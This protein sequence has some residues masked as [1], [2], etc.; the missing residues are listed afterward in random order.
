MEIPTSE[1]PTL[2]EL[3]TILP[4]CRNWTREKRVMIGLLCLLCI[5]IF[6]ISSNSRL[7]LHCAKRLMDREAF[8]RYLWGRVGF[9]SLLESIKVLTYEGKKSY[10]LHS[11]VHVLLI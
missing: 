2:K 11:Y 9:N 10:T 5:G 3:Q 1:G 6:G 4:I 7:P 8:Q